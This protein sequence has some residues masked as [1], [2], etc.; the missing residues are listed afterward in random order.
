MNWATI[1]AWVGAHKYV[2]AL[3]AAGVAGAGYYFVTHR[4]SSST[5]TASDAATAYSPAQYTVPYGPSDESGGGGG[6]SGSGTTGPGTSPGSDTPQPLL[7]YPPN[8]NTSIQVPMQGF[9]NPN[10]QVLAPATPST[11]STAPG[12]GT[13]SNPSGYTAP[14]QPI[15]ISVSIGASGPSAQFPVGTGPV[16][17]NA[18]NPNANLTQTTLQA[19]HAPIPPASV[20]VK[21]PAPVKA[22]VGFNTSTEHALT[23]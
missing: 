9:Q 6:G 8:P 3:G 5:A 7:G 13:A 19:L 15:P 2:V 17:I 21:T 12:A 10:S 20:V 22:T 14:A 23:Q 11:M 1:S 16:A 4:N 18:V